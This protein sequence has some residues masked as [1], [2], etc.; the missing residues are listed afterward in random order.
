MYYYVYS[1]HYYYNV[2]DLCYLVIITVCIMYTGILT[3]TEWRDQD[4]HFLENRNYVNS[5]NF[6]SVKAV[7]LP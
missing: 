2:Q 6:M 7:F 5:F 1:A 3:I 4:L